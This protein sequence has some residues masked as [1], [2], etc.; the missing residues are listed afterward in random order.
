MGLLEELLHPFEERGTQWPGVLLRRGL[1]RLERLALLR[2]EPVG[3]FQDE[4]IARIAVTATAELRHALAAQP[5]HLVRLASGGDLE[6]R[7]SAEDGDL[8]LG[9]QSELGERHGQIAVEIGAVAAEQLVLD[10]PA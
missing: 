3:H 10:E 5:Q 9:A 8:E 1:E 7:R 2:I 4:A 6:L